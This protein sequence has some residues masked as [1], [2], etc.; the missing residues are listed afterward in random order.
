MRKEAWPWIGTTE[1]EMGSMA[2]CGDSDLDINNDA[3][4]GY[5]MLSPV[6]YNHENMEP[7]S[8]GEGMRNIVHVDFS[9]LQDEEISAIKSMLQYLRASLEP[10]MTVGTV[11]SFGVKCSNVF[12]NKD[13]NIISLSKSSQNSAV[14]DR[15]RKDSGSPMFH[16]FH[17]KLDRFI[18]DTAGSSENEALLSIKNL[19]EQVAFDGVGIILSSSDTRIDELIEKSGF[20]ILSQHKGL[21]QKYL[22]KACSA[23]GIAIARY[24]NSMGDVS[25]SF[26]CDVADTFEKKKDGLQ[27]YSKLKKECG[28]LF[29]YERPTDVMFHMGSVSYPIDVIF[30]DENDNIKKISK[31][32]K[33][34]SLEV[35]GSSGISNVLEIS[36]GLCS[37]LDIKV[38]GK[39]YFTRGERHQGEMHKLSS[40]ASE[41][42]VKRLAFKEA[43]NGASAAYKVAGKNIIKIKKGEAPSVSSVIRKFASK[44]VYAKHER[45]AIDIDSLISS[46]GK[47]RLYEG[48]SPS[49]KKR[50]Y[51]GLHNETY[52]LKSD[53]Y[54]DIPSEVF[55]KKGSYTS[56]G[57]RFVFIRNKSLPI[58]FSDE[59][60]KIFKKI[61]EN[62]AK[63][64]VL[65]SRASLDKGLIETFLE[66]AIKISLGNDVSVNIELLQIPETFGTKMAYRAVCEKYGETD[67]YSYSFVKEGGVP[68]SKDVKDK[69]RTALRYLSRSSDMC[70]KLV[71]NFNLN[72]NAYSKIDGN[73]E[74]IAN[75]KGKYSQSC[76]RNSR[77]TKRMLL[78]IK[79]GIQ[80][81]NE[82][83][84][85][86]TTSEIIG[87][88]AE[89]AKVSSDLI[90]DVIDLTDVIDTDD[91]VSR[92]TETT[93]KLD[94]SLKDTILT[95][96]RGKDYINSEIL[97]ILV[98]TE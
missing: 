7:E 38:G 84:D 78:S 18:L 50:V 82:I 60:K 1:S 69:A 65:I 64:L 9:E 2:P 39:L 70:Q 94:S 11:G 52:S 92:L 68:V 85:I 23:D 17:N 57:E 76:K 41:L 58:K 45:I 16:Q 8:G 46:F 83:K 37:L 22:V 10:N 72:L 95:L 24:H 77:H 63:E 31:N 81:L 32:I 97:G 43:K 48:F 49:K 53:S 71:D 89:A 20:Q 61:K 75:S 59:H 96:D 56:L 12:L 42:G 98:L 5:D 15:I 91:F 13:V 35:F 3:Y 93:G 40:F 88:I 87:S 80:I 51:R 26:L 66:R 86:S 90:K 34:G 14:D 27:V 30:V 6:K 36:G 62:I 28:L 74:A 67:L 44:K 33:P 21:R 25:A 54:I 79:S 47:I 29:P 55:F 4:E 73:N 19:S